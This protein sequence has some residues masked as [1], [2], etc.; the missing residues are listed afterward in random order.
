MSHIKHPLVGDNLYGGRPRLPK[1]A[2][3]SFVNMLRGFKR[4]ALH[5]AQLSLTHPITQE[6]MTFQAPL[7]EDFVQLLAEVRE[8]TKING[9]DI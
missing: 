1:N 8:D 9:I 6:E 5:A 4:Q 7:P 3:E 2:S